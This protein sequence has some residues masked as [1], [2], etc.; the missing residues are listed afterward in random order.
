MRVGLA[1]SFFF[2]SVRPLFFSCEVEEVLKVVVV[3]AETEQVAV[4]WRYIINTF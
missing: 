3:E 4:E 2:V 1:F